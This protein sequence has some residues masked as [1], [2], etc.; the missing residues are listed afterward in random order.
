MNNPFIIADQIAKIKR[1]D[2]QTSNADVLS[3]PRP[4]PPKQE[5]SPQSYSTPKA[6]ERRSINQRKY[7]TSYQVPVSLGKA[8]ARRGTGLNNLQ[9]LN[10]CD[11]RSRLEKTAATDD[12]LTKRALTV[13]DHPIIVPS[14]P[15]RAQGLS[16]HSSAHNLRE[17][18]PELGRSAP[19]ARVSS[20]PGWLKTPTR[21]PGNTQGRL[22]RVVSA[23]GSTLPRL[24]YQ[25]DDDSA[26]AM[27]PTSGAKPSSGQDKSDQTRKVRPRASLLAEEVGEIE[28]KAVKS[29][30]AM[31]ISLQS[32]ATQPSAPT[33]AISPDAA[34]G[35]S[36]K[37]NSTAGPLSPR[38]RGQRFAGRPQRSDSPAAEVRLMDASVSPGGSGAKI[39]EGGETMLPHVSVWPGDDVGD[40]VGIQG[41]TIVLHLRGKDDLVISTDLSNDA[42]SL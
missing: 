20:P 14:T 23:G 3:V 17:D 25:R 13:D 10:P 22:K 21:A 28:M 7:P 31:N 11:I 34:G 2:P 35:L 33:T 9:Q 4:S 15:K 1:A 5:T 38:A 29:Q 18:H 30:R 40:D 8:S 27:S 24:C 36:S 6:Q 37:T 32:P 42:Q 41:L 26:D 16:Q 19:R 12:G 39:V